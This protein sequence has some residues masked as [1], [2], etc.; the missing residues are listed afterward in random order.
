L[1]LGLLELFTVTVFAFI[2]FSL[3]LAMA[4]AI[5]AAFPWS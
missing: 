2:R 3:F 1:V 4:M 5:S